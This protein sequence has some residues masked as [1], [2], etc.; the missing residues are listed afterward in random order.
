MRRIKTVLSA[1]LALAVAAGLCGCMRSRQEPLT[2]RLRGEL[3]K[4]PEK[5]ETEG[6]L[7]VLKVY[8]IDGKKT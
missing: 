1:V 2:W 6:G 5:L 7:P 8:N 4:L 3:P